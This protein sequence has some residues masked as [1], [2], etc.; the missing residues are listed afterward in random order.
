MLWDLYK[1]IFL[2]FKAYSVYDKAVGYCQGSM[3]IAG[4]LLMKVQ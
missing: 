4:M 3:F 1:S 2:F